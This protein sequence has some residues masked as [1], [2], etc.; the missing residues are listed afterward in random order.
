MTLST[1]SA[2]VSSLSAT[3]SA[4]TINAL[5]AGVHTILVRSQD[6]AL[7][8]GTTTSVALTV[9]KTG[10]LTSG[11]SASPN[12]NNGTLGV[13]STNPSVRVQAT[14]DDA[15]PAF[16]K[17]GE[18]FIDV[19]GAAGSGIPM[20]PA[21]GLF[22][23]AHEVGYVDV[24]LTTIAPLTQGNHTI[25]IHGKD[26]IATGPTAPV[27]LE[28]DKTG[29]TTSGVTFVPPAANAQA[30]AVSAI[31]NDVATGN[32]NVVA[33][34]F[35]I[36]TTSAANGTGTAMTAALPSPNATIGG[37]M[38]AATTA[39]LS[40]GLPPLRPCS[41]RR[42][43]LGPARE[44]VLPDRSHGATFSSIS[45]SPN[46]IASGT[47]NTGLTVN[48]ASDGASGSGVGG[49]EFWIANS[50]VPA[51]GGT[52]FNGLTASPS[53]PAPWSRAR[54]PCASGSATS[55]ATGARVTTASAP[56]P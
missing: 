37:T 55:P 27:T 28:I 40:T 11:A 47:A 46:S 7:N 18:V 33:G 49:G 8:W 32:H 31:G 14:F 15:A 1:T 26:S 17:S 3:I 56:R 10:P 51:G 12:P 38:P 43:Q 52:P 30:V 34:E 53:R 54:T 39:G 6:V 22:N 13:N 45:L 20:V 19:V 5:T 50:N 24:P 16:V 25:Y 9:D 36:D 23:T 4:A 35:F 29:P 41:R 48:G 42:R 44:R 21:D 2:P